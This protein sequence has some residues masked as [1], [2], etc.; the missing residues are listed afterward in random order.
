M[1]NNSYSQYVCTAVLVCCYWL[2]LLLMLLHMLPLYCMD[3]KEQS[4][5]Q[6]H[7]RMY[8]TGTGTDV[9]SR[10][11]CTVMLEFTTAMYAKTLVLAPMVVI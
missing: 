7:V 5:E 10:D 6:L 2:P 3:S 9:S 8:Q 4:W 11:R 1:A